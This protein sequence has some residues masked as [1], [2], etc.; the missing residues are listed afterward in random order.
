[1]TEQSLSGRLLAATPQLGDPNFRRT[2][3]LIVEDDL[4]EGTLGVVLNR[5][6][7]VP[8]DQ[9]LE[10]WTGLATGPPVVFRGGPISPNSALAL[11]LVPGADEPVGW[12]S[13]DGTPVMSRLGLVDLGAPPELLAGGITSMRVFAGYAGWGAGQLRDEIDEGAW[14]VLP[15]DPADAFAADPEHLWQTVLRRQGG[16]L[17]LVATFPDDPMWN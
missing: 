16:D 10:A 8:L 14:Y 3:V 2:V 7:E 12:R 15:G 1:M 6:T 4:E 9:V 11:A 17:A 5:P 13:L